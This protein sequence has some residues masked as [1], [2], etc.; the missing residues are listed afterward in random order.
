MS[1]KILILADIGPENFVPR[2]DAQNLEVTR[3][4]LQ[5]LAKFH[6]LSYFMN[7][8]N[9]DVD[10]Y[11]EGFVS[12]RMAAGLAMFANSFKLAAQVLKD[13]GKDFE[14]YGDRILALMPTL[15]PKIMKI[16]TANPPGQGFNVLNHGDFH[17]R[18][19]MFNSDES[20]KDPDFIRF[21]S[22]DRE[23]ICLIR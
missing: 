7:D 14:V 22:E 15:L 2:K 21:V 5:K 3:K 6:G 20:V 23:I 16:Y 4:V 13:W 8:S 11:R 19:I 9:E 18:N 1:P 17:I 10:T 12:E